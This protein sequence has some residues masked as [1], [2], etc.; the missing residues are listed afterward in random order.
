MR[1]L[2]F[3]ELNSKC[4]TRKNFLILPKNPIYVIAHNIRSLHNVGS[5]FRTSDALKI[6]KL[7]LTGFTGYPPRDEIEKVA[8]GATET[9]SW[10]YNKDVFEII[11][12]LKKDKV[13]IIVLEQTDKSI[14][15]Q[16]FNYNFPIA[17]I[18]GNEYDGMP[19]EVIKVLDKS[20]EI[21]M[22][23]TKQSL[24]VATSFGIIGYELL[25]RLKQQ[26]G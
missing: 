24:N 21:P 18:L 16:E 1:K 5:I 11:D 23:G 26:G 7:F 17:I 20:V 15:F 13:E 8:L 9:V 10:E 25:R 12:R 22:Y 3:D 2:T 4:L 14:D 19:D 6:E